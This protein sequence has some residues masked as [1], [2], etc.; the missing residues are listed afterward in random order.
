MRGISKYSVRQHNHVL[1]LKP[2][3]VRPAI[4]CQEKFHLSVDYDRATQS[5]HFETAGL[6]VFHPP[7]A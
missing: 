4:K 7:E 5:E 6:L 2:T 1:N 3:D